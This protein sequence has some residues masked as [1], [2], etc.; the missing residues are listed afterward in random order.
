MPTELPEFTLVG[1]GLAGA[2]LGCYLGQAGKRVDIFEALPDPARR[3][4][5]GGRSINL[6]LSAR[7]LRSLRDVGLADAVLSRAVPM[8]GRMIHAA[9]TAPTFQR[10]S[11][12]PTDAL[13][14]VSRQD[15]H[16]LL[17]EK[18]R[19]CP[20]VRLH[21]EHRCVGYDPTTHKVQMHCPSGD[22]RDMEAGRLLAADGS[23]SAV[24]RGLQ[25][26]G[27]AKFEEMR[28]THGYKELRIPSRTVGTPA[29]EANALH[30]WPRQSFMLIALPNIDGSF[31]TT[32]FLPLL[33]SNSF[34]TLTHFEDAERF[35]RHHF[36]DA[37]PL[38]DDLAREWSANP[39]G[40]LT[41]I[42]GGPWYVGE[43]VLLLG[44]A[45]HAV[46][47]FLGQGMNAAFEDCRTLVELLTKPD[48][49]WG[50][51]FAEF[52]TR[53]KPN[54][55]ALAEMSLENFHEM[56]DR[57]SSTLFRWKKQWNQRFAGTFNG[58]G[59]RSLHEMISFTEIPYAQARR[60]VKRRELGLWVF[61]LLL[62]VSTVSLIVY[63]CIS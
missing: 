45:S 60:M 12:I 5:C 38:F 27:F 17:I 8:R 51:V 30:I 28:L 55:D 15:I 41:T 6:A 56:R 1:A 59:F 7:G 50:R 52:Q 40:T 9:N 29:L 61:F 31:T 54:T 33:G 19:A 34:A 37:L 11:S 2:L 53:R 63:I 48:Q 49:A 18:A 35:F 14:S 10:Y 22:L 39:V 42:V 25:Q 3:I 21:F 57:T 20:S 23:N 32:L 47:P 58:R 36:A 13:Y 24:R 44:D 62:V 4:V 16:S 26:T 46:T 43:R